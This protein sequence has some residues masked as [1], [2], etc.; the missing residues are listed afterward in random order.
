MTEA[1]SAEAGAALAKLKKGEAVARAE[2]LLAGT[3]WLPHA[4]R[5]R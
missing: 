5:P 2:A 3:R 4:L 1:V